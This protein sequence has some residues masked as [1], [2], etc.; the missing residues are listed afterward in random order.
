MDISEIESL[1]IFCLLWTFGINLT[2]KDKLRY[3]N[4]LWDDSSVL[5]PNDNLF[6]YYIDD[7]SWILWD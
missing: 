1:Y 4:F 5:I 2:E 7:R 3:M 6:D